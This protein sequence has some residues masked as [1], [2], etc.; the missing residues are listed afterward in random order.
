MFCPLTPTLQAQE[1]L[2][3][4][5]SELRTAITATHTAVGGPDA[6]AAILLGLTDDGHNSDNDSDNEQ[7][8]PAADAAARAAAGT[9]TPRTAAAAQAPRQGSIDMDGDGVLS[10]P[11]ESS[12]A[13]NAH[14]RALYG[15]LGQVL[16]LMTG[17]RFDWRDVAFGN[18]HGTS[19]FAPTTAMMDINGATKVRHGVLSMCPVQSTFSN[20]LRRS[21]TTCE[22]P[23]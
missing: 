7:D 16:Y 8:A 5:Y 11:R 13:L 17:I 2:K 9:P 23:V 19:M 21:L 12:A 22:L 14:V 20:T 10:Q 1:L 15:A 4:C 3:K 6:A 18:E